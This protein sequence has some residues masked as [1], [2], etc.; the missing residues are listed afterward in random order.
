MRSVVRYSE[1]FKLQVVRELE[2]GRFGSVAEA[3]RAY[4]VRGSATVDAWI[5]RFGKDH[6]LGKVVRVMKADERAEVE[7]LRKQVRELKAALADAHIDSR[8]DAAY[9]KIACRAAGIEDVEA[10]KKARWEAVNEVA[11]GADRDASVAALCSRVGM[12]RQ[13]YYYD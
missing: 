1:A 3:R 6:L 10:F 13:N 12:S 8:L 4:G 2:Q 9:L 5:R 11:D 7:A